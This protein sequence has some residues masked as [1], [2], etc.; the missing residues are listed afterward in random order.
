MGNNI[1]TLIRGGAEDATG[2]EFSD[3]DSVLVLNSDGEFRIER[4]DFGGG[5]VYFNE[6]SI[7]DSLTPRENYRSAVDTDEYDYVYNFE[8]VSRVE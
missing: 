6:H 8:M 7:I 1:T 5:R 3:M 4:S 2:I